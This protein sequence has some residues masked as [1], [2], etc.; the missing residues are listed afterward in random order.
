V[1]D[2][3]PAALLERHAPLVRYATG[4]RHGATAVEALTALPLRGARITLRA[5]PASAPRPDVTY[6]RVARGGDGRVWLQYWFLHED[7]PQD[8]GIVRTG[9]HEG[10]WEVVQ[11]GLDRSEARPERMT[12][13]QHAWAEACPWR[14]V[15]RTGA[16]GAVPVVHVAAAS[17]ASY[18]RA[19]DH[20]RPFPDPT[21]A[22]DGRGRAVRPDVR[23][24]GAWV[25][26]PGR[27]GRSDPSPLVP[28]ESP[29]PRGPAFQEEGPWRDPSAFHARARPCGSGAPPH[30]PG[31]R[32]GA[33]GAVLLLLA[34][35]AACARRRA[36]RRAG[37]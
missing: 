26:W 11:V 14:R 1:P 34:L 3:P 6:G 15:E 12:F 24:F 9:R 32:L 19:G 16:D 36:R 8:R 22:A 23:P 18:P 21:D 31:V 30:P 29:S 20:D 2:L 7:N 4:E 5:P 27:W 28:G 13:A 25:R 37:R 35:A 33:A 10:D 17:H